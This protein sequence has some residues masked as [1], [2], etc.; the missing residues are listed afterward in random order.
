MVLEATIEYED[1]VRGESML[2]WGVK[3]AREL[4]VED[5]MLDAGAHVAPVWKQYS[6]GL[7]QVGELPMSRM[8][9]G[10][11]GA[12]NLHHPVACQALI[13]AAAA[14]GAKVVR[15][16]R[17]VKL[18][19]G[20]SPTVSYVAS[21]QTTEVTTSLV[22]GA[23][24]RASTV[25][26]QAGIILERQEPISHIAGLLVDGLDDVPDDHDVTATEDDLMFLMLHQG[27]GR[28]RLYLAVGLGSPLVDWRR[29]DHKADPIR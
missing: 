9:D 4:G 20:G 17:E 18:A 25:R 22:V 14:Q 23:N 3:E 16:V 26:K 19:S 11:P 10:I 15:G 8:V 29:L 7:G 2:P 28:A 24:G 12:L 27:G 21:G 6:E 5:V 1:R 13:D